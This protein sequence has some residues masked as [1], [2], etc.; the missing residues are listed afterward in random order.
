M[1]A[2]PAPHADPLMV[3]TFAE[4]REAARELLIHGIPPERVTW[5][6]PHMGDLLGASDLFTGA[7]PSTEASD[8]SSISPTEPSTEPSAPLRPV[9]YVP[10]SLMEML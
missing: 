10:R 6:A 8:N 7:P 5:G 9:P 3:E 4:W 1:S 2:Q